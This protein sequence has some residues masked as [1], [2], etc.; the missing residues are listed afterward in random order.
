MTIHATITRNGDGL[1]NRHVIDAA[2]S[3]VPQLPGY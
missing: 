3:Q 2:P 1:D